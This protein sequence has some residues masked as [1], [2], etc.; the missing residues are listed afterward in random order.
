M[1][2]DDRVAH[3]VAGRVVSGFSKDGMRAPCFSL[4]DILGRHVTSF[5]TCARSAKKVADKVVAV[6]RSKT[7][8]AQSVL[9]P[10]VFVGACM[11]KLIKTSPYA[12]RDQI[13]AHGGDR[14]K[15][16][17]R[18]VGEESPGLLLIRIMHSTLAG[19]LLYQS[20]VRRTSMVGYFTRHAIE[21]FVKRTGSIK[22][23]A[24]DKELR[25]SM[26]SFVLAEAMAIAHPEMKQAWAPTANGIFIG[27]VE[28]D[29]NS[30]FSWITYTTFID[31]ANLSGKWVAANRVI[32]RF[33]GSVS[34]DV[35][36]MTG[37]GL[38]A[39][40][41]IFLFCQHQR[42][43]EYKLTLGAADENSDESEA[44]MS[45]VMVLVAKNPILRVI[46]EFIYSND[47]VLLD[48]CESR[49]AFDDAWSDPSRN[50]M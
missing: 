48:H 17:M 20:E 50:A 33:M 38:S 39:E 10:D 15:L 6:A 43:K 13:D 46:D 11:F 5:A 23:A 34:Y 41:L 45:Q 49:D 14:T 1:R 40:H 12:V 24:F 28:R 31:K 30:S 18:S 22:L 19:S 8:L 9:A 36:K 29:E 47:W 27:F 25:E 32:Q 37:G 44:S 42:L 2:L 35:C 21:R 7:L 4:A 16:N 26:D 3:K